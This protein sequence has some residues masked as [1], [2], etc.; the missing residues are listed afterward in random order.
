AFLTTL[1]AARLTA[2]PAFRVVFPTD[3]TA[4]R[5]FFFATTPARRTA[6]LVDFLAFF[7]VVAIRNSLGLHRLHS[8][9]APGLQGPRDH[10]PPLSCWGPAAPLGGSGMRH[11]WTGGAAGAS[12]HHPQLQPRPQPPHPRPIPQ[13]PYPWPYW[14]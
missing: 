8:S 12:R 3:L 4:L 7:R 13:P 5:A 11:W 10:A 2:R 9:A 6:A 1:F 14:I